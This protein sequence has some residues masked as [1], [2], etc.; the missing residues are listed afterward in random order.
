MT[1]RETIMGSSAKAAIHDTSHDAHDPLAPV[2]AQYPLPVVRGEGVWLHTADGR[3]VLGT[4][5]SL[6]RGRI[7]H[8]I[9]V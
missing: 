3:R 7:I 4:G 9:A 1:S 8:R 6:A 2:F 5:R